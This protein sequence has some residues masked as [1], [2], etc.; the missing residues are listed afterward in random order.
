MKGYKK[1]YGKI[2]VKKERDIKMDERFL[3][4]LII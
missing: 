2:K 1:R 3:K 4:I